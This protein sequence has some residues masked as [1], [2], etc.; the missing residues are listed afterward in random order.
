MLPCPYYAR[1]VVKKCL[2]RNTAEL[3]RR[4]EDGLGKFSAGPLGGIV[5]PVRNV[6]PVEEQNGQVHFFIPR[7][8]HSVASEQGRA[9]E[10]RAT[11]SLLFGTAGLRTLP[12]YK[13]N[14]LPTPLHS[15][16]R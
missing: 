11:S 14:N 1:D 9:G 6:V 10:R 16:V 15:F 5:Q 4:I 7:F 13:F 12:P 8:I 2:E 3:V